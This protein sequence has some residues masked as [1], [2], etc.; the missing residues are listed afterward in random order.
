MVEYTRTIPKE[1][2]IEV[3]AKVTIPQ[4]PIQGCTQKIELKVTH[5]YTVNKAA[6]MLPFQIDEAARRVEN[7]EEEEN[8]D[9]QKDGAKIALVGQEVRLNNRIIDLRVPAN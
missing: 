8:E 6:P 7:Q 9:A 1:S 4:T 3:R 5:I 2:I